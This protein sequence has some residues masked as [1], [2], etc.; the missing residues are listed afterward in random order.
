MAHGPARPKPNGAILKDEADDDVV[1]LDG[2]RE[3][4]V[5]ITTADNRS[6]LNG[7]ALFHKVKNQKSILAIIVSDSKIFAGTQGG[8]LL[9]GLTCLDSDRFSS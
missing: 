4:V 9:V 5:S 2:H 3:R 8:E 1:D 6:A 7:P